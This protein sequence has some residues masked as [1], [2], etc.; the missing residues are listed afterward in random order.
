[1]YKNGNKRHKEKCI[2]TMMIRKCNYF[3]SI[4]K[5]S[6]LIINQTMPRDPEENTHFGDPCF[7][8]VWHKTKLCICSQP[9][10]WVEFK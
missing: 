2:F 9:I 5:E 10:L 8:Q 4:N 1:M 7:G 6:S 3:S